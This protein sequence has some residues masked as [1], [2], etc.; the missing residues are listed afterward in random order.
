MNTVTNVI[1]PPSLYEMRCAAC[2][3][4]AFK[5]TAVARFGEAKLFGLECAH[6]RRK[7]KM[8]DAS[9]FEGSTNLRMKGANDH[10]YG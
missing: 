9:G 8:D 3:H 2:N 6:C 10:G 5:A 1:V 4:A 7:Y